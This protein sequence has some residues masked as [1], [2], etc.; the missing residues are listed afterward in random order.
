MGCSGGE[1]GAPDARGAGAGPLGP[2][3]CLNSNNSIE[4]APCERTQAVENWRLSDEFRREK[5]QGKRDRDGRS[6]G[7]DE[8]GEEVWFGGLTASEKKNSYKLGLNIAHLANKHG[9][10]RLGFLTLTF[11]GNVEDPKEGQR[12]FNSLATNLLRKHFTEYLCVVERQKRGAIHY[13]LIV[14]CEKDIRTGVDFDGLARRD[15]R[16]ASKYL[17]LLWKVLRESM[18]L[19]GFGRPELLPIKS[20]ASGISNYVGK[21]LTKASAYRGEHMKGARLIRYSQRW[22]VAKGQIAWVSTGARQW[23]QRVAQ[24]AAATGCHD[25][26]ALR[27]KHG[28]YW[29]M[30]LAAT[31]TDLEA[32]GEDFE[33]F[34]EE[35]KWSVS[36]AQR[37]A[38]FTRRCQ[39]RRSQERS[40]E[41]L[42]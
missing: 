4:N 5:K 34:C 6:K 19:Y 21:Y 11:V 26:E 42:P 29:A 8:N 35:L 16:S 2:L 22:A 12:R 25:L 40:D 9:I 7:K 10:E 13:H 28:R 41:K 38:N 39:G 3:P 32:A 18:P 27:R 17:R 36:P 14:V 31:L 1:R 20:T 24:F 33:A 30:S 23:R 37:R 15:Y